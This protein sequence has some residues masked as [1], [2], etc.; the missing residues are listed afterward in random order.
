MRAA[1]ILL[2]II[3]LVALVACAT[4]SQNTYRT[5]YTAGTSYDMAM[6]TVVTLQKQ[7][8]ISEAQRKEIN[9]LANFYYVAYQTSVTAFETWK[10]TDTA[11]DKVKVQ[12]VLFNVFSK[13]REFAAYVNRLRPSTLPPELEEVK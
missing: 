11:A 5:L 3:L 1:R 2:P 9:T 8:V 7:G 4:F 12:T 10:K 13:W 6:N